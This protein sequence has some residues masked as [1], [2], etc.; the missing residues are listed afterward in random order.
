MNEWI[1]TL[2]FATCVR[3]KVKNHELGRI[4]NEDVQS[5]PQYH[6][7]NKTRSNYISQ[8]GTNKDVNDDYDDND[9]NDDN[10]DD[11][12]GNDI[13]VLWRWY[14]GDITG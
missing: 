4:L 11:N 13:V 7:K 3:Q 1:C 8:G 2:I 12:D 6:H 10:D 5:N 14:C 9:D